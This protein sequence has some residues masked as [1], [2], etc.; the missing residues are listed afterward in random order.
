MPARAPGAETFA[1][2]AAA[3][4]QVSVSSAKTANASA[5]PHAPLECVGLM[6]AAGF[7][8]A[9]MTPY[10]IR[11]ANVS[12]RRSVLDLAQRQTPNVARFVGSS[13]GLAAA[14]ET[15]LAVNAN[16]PPFV[17]LDRVEPMVVAVS[18]RASV[19]V[20]VLLMVV[21]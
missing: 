5:P 20:F 1:Q 16:A 11:K 12:I 4:V 2:R 15:V 17:L 10:A 8:D 18:V 14:T 3:V 9:V 21:V 6:A 7:V 19:A 13:V